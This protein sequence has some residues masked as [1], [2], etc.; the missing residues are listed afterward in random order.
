M[1]SPRGHALATGVFF[2]AAA[3]AAI[4]GLVLYGPLL[5]HA[6]YVIGAGADTR[7]H[8]IPTSPSPA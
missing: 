3:V 2:I 7:I 5:N 4:A 6:D 1:D 8:S